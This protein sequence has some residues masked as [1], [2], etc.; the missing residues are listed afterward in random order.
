MTRSKRFAAIGA[1]ALIAVMG[2]LDLEVTNPNEPDADRALATPGD[3][4]ALVAGAYNVWFTGTYGLSGPGL[5][6]SNA[7]FQH[8]SPW[9]NFG[10]DQYGRIPREPIVNDAA[11]PHYG[12]FTQ[13]WYDMYR[14]LAAVA[15]GLKALNEDPS[16][17]QELGTVGVDRLRAYGKFVQG[18]AH[19]SIALLY[20]QGF[21]LDESIDPG[22]SQEPVDYHAM[23]DAALGYFADAAALASA[24]SFEIPGS[25]IPVVAPPMSASGRR[26]R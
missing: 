9:A 20:D 4:E 14:A 2:C 11:D 22:T 21:I 23:M 5:F 7:S 16:V 10:M 6:L 12:Y 1:L 18:M 3:I 15:D 8:S 24:S 25:W 13:P 19:G 17:A 26:W